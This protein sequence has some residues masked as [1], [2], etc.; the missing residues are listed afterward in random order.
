MARHGLHSS[1][2]PPSSSSGTVDPRGRAFFNGRVGEDWGMGV[3]VSFCD[4]LTR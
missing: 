4:A 1:L 2:A 3:T